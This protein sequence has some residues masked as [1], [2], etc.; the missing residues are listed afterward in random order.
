MIFY[1][2]SKNNLHMYFVNEP[3]TKTYSYPKKKSMV[4]DI[5]KRILNLNKF[6][7]KWDNLLK[8]T[9]SKQNYTSFKTNYIAKEYSR[10]FL[11]CL[12]TYDKNG[13]KKLIFNVSAYSQHT[14]FLKF[15]ILKTLFYKYIRFMTPSFLIKL[16]K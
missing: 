2:L 6:L 15:K 12:A 9:F 4:N 7:K 11:K 10:L 16:V 8:L 1:E 5:E 13:L 14:R 3:L